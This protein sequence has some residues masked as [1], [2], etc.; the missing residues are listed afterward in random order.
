MRPGITPHFPIHAH[1]VEIEPD[2]LTV[3]GATKPWRV[4]LRGVSA[5][6]TVAGAAAASDALGT[7][8]TP[9]PNVSGLHIQLAVVQARF[10]MDVIR[11][12]S[13]LGEP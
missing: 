5:I 13:E 1:E 6:Q 4:L 10:S 9:E 12:A 2:A 11:R 8:L 3:H 7:L